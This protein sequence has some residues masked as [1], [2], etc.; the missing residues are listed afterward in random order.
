MSLSFA[1]LWQQQEGSDMDV[2]LLAPADAAA[3]SALSSQIQDEHA[4]LAT[5]AALELMTF[6]AHR[7]LFSNSAVLWCRVSGIS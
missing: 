4:N 1:H 2:I 3:S 7:T 5:P 6:P